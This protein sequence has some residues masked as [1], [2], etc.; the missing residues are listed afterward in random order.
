[1]SEK[2]EKKVKKVE[3]TVEEMLVDVPDIPM[4]TG[5][6][7]SE[8]V[9]DE[10]KGAFR[11]AFIGTGQGGSRIAE[12]FWRLGYRRVCCVNTNK[13]DLASI[14][15]PESNKLIMD[16]GTGGAGKD[17]VKGEAAAKQ[18]YEDV[19]D[20]MRRSFGREFDRIIVCVGGGGGT[21]GGSA[22]TL[23]G[24]AHDIC[25]SFKVETEGGRPTV[26]AIV[27]LPKVTEG[28]KVNEN[29]Y[30]LLESLFGLVGKDRGK[31]GGRTLSP[32][33]IMDNDRIN[34]IYPNLPV[35][36]FWDVA[37]R[38]VS[39][40]FHLFNSIALQDSE[41]T[42]F[43]RADFEDILDSGVVSFGACP[44]KKWESLTD[45]SFSIRDNL[46]NNVLVGGFDLS[47][48]MTAGCVFVGSPD[49]L[50]SIPQEHLEHGF[51][52]LSRIMRQGGTVHRGIYKG[53]K[54]GLVV[55]SALGELGRPESRMGE[56]AKAG[57][58]KK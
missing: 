44:I 4:P 26:G 7:D 25:Q 45:I 33:I 6:S 48:A 40:L 1:M 50:N 32:L 11:L 15:I 52:M 42:T 57:G 51:E 21:G 55:Y 13:Q 58:M 9:H 31:M 28:G 16:I 39:A 54:P 5:G 10:C 24:I 41:F 22:R 53:A 3:S 27:S 34:R 18:Y 47:Q 19:Y 38:S 46:K 17:P 36:E 30:Y 35:S 12:A 37:N 20:L 43:D 29:A 8:S 23:V 14:G 2:L 56:M 49:V